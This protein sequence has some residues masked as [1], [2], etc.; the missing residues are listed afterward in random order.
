MKED[1]TSLIVKLRE[2]ASQYDPEEPEIQ[3]ALSLTNALEAHQ[4][5]DE[6]AIA[7]WK[8]TWVIARE[9]PLTE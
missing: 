1:L 4:Q 5:G 3:A 9:L 2:A 8:T 6:T 7:R